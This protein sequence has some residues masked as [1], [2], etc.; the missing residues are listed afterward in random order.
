MQ[1]TVLIEAENV[2]CTLI[3]GDI[4]YSC[5]KEK[6]TIDINEIEIVFDAYKN[7]KNKTKLKVIVEFGLL[8]IITEDARKHLEKHK[9]KA[10]CEALIISGL[11]QRIV[12]R[13]YLKFKSH[14]HPSK[15]F[16]N[17]TNALKWVRSH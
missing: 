9:E 3:D 7:L 8:A 2:Y 11:S 15:V 5:Y 16:K 14:K 1:E 12:L 4:F 10:L 6:S 17:K 13:F